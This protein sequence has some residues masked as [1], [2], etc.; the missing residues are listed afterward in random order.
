MNANDSCSQR[1]W[2][3][4]ETA[5]GDEVRKYKVFNRTSV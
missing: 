3:Q 5:D 1:G 4:Y 2:I